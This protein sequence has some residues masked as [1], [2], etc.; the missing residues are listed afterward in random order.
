MSRRGGRAGSKW[1]GHKPCTIARRSASGDP[2]DRALGSVALG[3]RQYAGR[4]ETIAWQQMLL[5]LPHRIFG[6]GRMD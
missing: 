2:V 6:D 3:V 4:P 5:D 1:C